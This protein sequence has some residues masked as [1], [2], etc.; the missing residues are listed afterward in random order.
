MVGGMIS[1]T[2]LTLVV[3]PAIYM[4]WKQRDLAGE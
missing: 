4:L 2:M 1:V 3:L